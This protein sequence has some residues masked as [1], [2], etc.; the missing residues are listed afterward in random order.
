V[1]ALAQPSMK[2]KVI[3][4]PGRRNSVWLGGS[5]LASL[6]AFPHMCV[7]FDEYREEGAQIVH[8]KCYC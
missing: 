2:V 4:T 6:E 1:I 7:T 8:R 5:I 3:A